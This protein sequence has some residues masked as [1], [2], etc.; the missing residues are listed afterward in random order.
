MTQ[1]I[2][3]HVGRNPG[4]LLAALTQRGPGEVVA[5]A[6][7]AATLAGPRVLERGER[8]LVAAGTADVTP[9]LERGEDALEELRGSFVLALWDGATLLLARDRFGERPLSFVEA[10]GELW[11]G[12]DANV[13]RAAGAPVGGLESRRTL[14]LSRASLRPG[15]ALD[16]E[17]GAKAACRPR[18]PFPRGQ[19]G[20]QPLRPD[21]GSGHR[22]R[23]RGPGK[24]RR[25]RWKARSGRRTP[26]ASSWPRAPPGDRCWPSRRAF[27]RWR[28]PT[29]RRTRARFRIRSSCKAWS[30]SGPTKAAAASPEPAGDASLVTLHAAFQAAGPIRALVPHGGAPIFADA[31]RY[32]TASRVPH[33]TRAGRIAAFLQRVAPGKHSA[34][35]PGR[36][37]RCPPPAAPA[38][39][40]WPRPS[41]P[42]TGAPSSIRR[43][44]AGGSRDASR[45]EPRCGARARSRCPGS[46]AL[47][48][49]AGSGRVARR[50]AGGGAVSRP[51]GRRA[52]GPD[53]GERKS[54]R[55]GALAIAVSRSAPRPAGGA[56]LARLARR[57][58][59]DPA[60]R[61]GPAT[62]GQ[63][64]HL[65]GSPRNER[66]LSRSLSPDG[67]PR[68]AYALLMLERWARA[69]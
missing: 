65:H 14:R 50:R 3:G 67:D 46:R 10:R 27:G 38:C 60:R 21:P 19:G 61:P 32:R 40:R 13:L 37:A 11:F 9:V 22:G 12:P 6:F 44:G 29:A 23:R 26:R 35:C 36:R 5:Q 41:P 58:L 56:S 20:A 28:L 45:A 43:R 59:A 62:V 53:P 25:A 1:G 17:R 47:P 2:A 63:D 33:S 64:P 49:R 30:S 48:A 68:Q 16:L 24:T 69:R 34:G 51:P 15:A 4:K 18:P 31:A 8:R 52:G 66:I 54:P 42:K 57:A 39:A 55:R 7:G